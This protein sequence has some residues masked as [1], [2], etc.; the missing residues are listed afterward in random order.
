MIKNTAQ[1]ASLVISV[2]TLHQILLEWDGCGMSHAC[3]LWI[4][5]A[6]FVL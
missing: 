3:Y 2:C 1:L 6:Y 4:R 5:N